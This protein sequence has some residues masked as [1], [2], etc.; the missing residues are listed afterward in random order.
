MKH[1]GQLTF[2][3]VTDCWD[4]HLDLGMFGAILS[5]NVVATCGFN[6]HNCVTF[7]EKRVE[8]KIMNIFKLD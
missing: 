1:N 5:C 6:S 4:T 7:F 8:A 3:L 2:Q